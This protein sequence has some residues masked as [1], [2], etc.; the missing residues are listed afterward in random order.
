V[1][2]LTSLR[3]RV[4][5]HPQPL[6][7]NYRNMTLSEYLQARR[8]TIEASIAAEELAGN[9]WKLA[10]EKTALAEIT[11]LEIA[12]GRGEILRFSIVPLSPGQPG[13]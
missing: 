4:P 10:C 6:L 3:V 13:A 7:R 5:A 2:A 11:A 12:V 8:N 1:A 9:D